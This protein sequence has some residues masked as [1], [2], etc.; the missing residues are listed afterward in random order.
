MI[1]ILF[2]RLTRFV[3]RVLS[4]AFV[5]A[6]ALNF[7]NVVGRY[8]LGYSIL[9]ADEV[10]IYIMVFMAFLGAAVVYWRRAHL[11]MDVLVQFFPAWMRTALRAAELA[12]IVLLA[13]FV[14]VQSTSYAWQMLAI[15]RKSDN[16]GIPM[17]IPHGAVALGFGLI[18]LIALWRGVRF[19]K[20]Q[21]VEEPRP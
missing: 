7:A 6:V 21:A 18:A 14:L 16:A 11:R 9:G 10:Q 4:L 5:F 1:D 12:L 15:D 8:V 2:E 17:W 3:E 13:G 20:E 19:A